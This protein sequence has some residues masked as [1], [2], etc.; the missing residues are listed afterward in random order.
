MAS[1]ATV[2]GPTRQQ[3]GDEIGDRTADR[4][5]DVGLRGC[6]LLHL[7]IMHADDETRDAVGLVDGE[8]ALGELDRFVDVAVG[9]RRDEGAVEQLVVLGIGAQGR[10]VE[11]SGGGRVALDAGM[12]GGEIATGTRE[13]LQIVSGRKLRRR[14]LRVIRR[15][16]Q[17]AAG[18]GRDRCAHEGDGSN[19]PAVETI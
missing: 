17:D 5:V 6:V 16:R 13:R 18:D 3:R 8:D 11:R 7:E 2:G 9:D 15:L 4:L 12:A 1:P 14:V 10:A 19:S